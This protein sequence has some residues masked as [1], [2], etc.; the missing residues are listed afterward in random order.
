MVVEAKYPV[1]IQD[2]GRFGVGHLGLATGGA[3]DFHA[4]C[5]ANKL[6]KNPSTAATLE[7]MNGK[8][9]IQAL[10]DSEIALT[11]AK[12]PF[13]INGKAREMWKVQ[14]I[15]SG[16][17]LEIASPHSGQISYL[18]L[19]GGIAS[20]SIKN[21]QSTVIRDQIGR[22]ITSNDLLRSTIK[23]SR[24]LID[25]ETPSQYIPNYEEGLEI[26]VILGYQYSDFDEEYID[27]FFNTNFQI[28]NKKDRMGVQLDGGRKKLVQPP[29]ISEGISL[30]AIQVTPE[31]VP[32]ILLKDHQTLGG[33]P[34][35]GCVAQRDQFKIAQA[36]EHQKI[37]FRIISRVNAQRDWKEFLQFFE[38]N[39]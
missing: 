14:H 4:H 26:N 30:G 6:L 34:K 23:K 22:F 13:F 17:F 28:S 33:Y 38:L 15:K 5:W 9:I 12:T 21:S 19:A 25:C 8:L 24:S 16:Q 2:L 10:T 31:G 32:I 29:L 36:R 7:I 37:E 18:A 27:Y 35:I 20:P 11:G 39:L 1:T 3:L